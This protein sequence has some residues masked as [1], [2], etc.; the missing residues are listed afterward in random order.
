MF[1]FHLSLRQNEK[2]FPQKQYRPV[3]VKKDGWHVSNHPV[4]HKWNFNY[5][6]TG[7]AI[8]H[9]LGLSESRVSSFPNS[10][11]TQSRLFSNCN[12]MRQKNKDLNIY[13]HDK[14]NDKSNIFWEILF[15][16]FCQHVGV[17]LVEL[18]VAPH[19]KLASKMKPQVD[20]ECC[21]Y[22]PQLFLQEKKLL[23]SFPIPSRCEMSFN[24]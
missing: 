15:D 16:V 4:V 7:A 9:W 24:I 13:L 17:Q 22:H 10:H 11:L 1:C 20:F 8:L 14:N 19:C 3:R 12:W 5:Q 21:V 23:K 2:D 6:D 18:V